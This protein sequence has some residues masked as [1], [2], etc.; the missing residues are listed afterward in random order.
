V[1]QQVLQRLEDDYVVVDVIDG[2]SGFDPSSIK[3]TSLGIAGLRERVE[4]LGGRFEIVSGP[5]G[6]MVTMSLKMSETEKT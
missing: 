4:S 1:G 2:G 3:S 5:D 6:T